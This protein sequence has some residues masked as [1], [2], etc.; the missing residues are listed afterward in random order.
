MT[1][2]VT[3]L[4]IH[5]LSARRIQ[6]SPLA[7]LLPKTLPQQM[8]IH[9]Q[10]IPQGARLLAAQKLTWTRFTSHDKPWA[11]QAWLDTF[12]FTQPAM[13]SPSPGACWQPES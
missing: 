3:S 13:A 9:R 1:M 4:W 11:A 2:R 6:M 7:L 10:R 12:H 8:L 5:R